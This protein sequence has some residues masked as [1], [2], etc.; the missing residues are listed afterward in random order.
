MV[1][2]HT[3]KLF[4]KWKGGFAWTGSGAP[5]LQ[6]QMRKVM[7]LHLQARGTPSSL[8][9]QRLFCTYRI[10][11]SSEN[12]F[13]IAV[14]SQIQ[15]FGIHMRQARSKLH[16]NQQDYSQMDT[17]AERPWFKYAYLNRDICVILEIRDISCR[18]LSPLLLLGVV[19][20]RW[21]P[22]DRTRAGCLG[23]LASKTKYVTRGTE[24]GA[25]SSHCWRGT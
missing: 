20:V 16:W 5:V 7:Q 25:I 21:W 22:S 3:L 4:L 13:L 12:V 10:N 18:Q 24:I 14:I 2:V 1:Y 6:K 8:N 9:I 11:T 19:V 23:V 17:I 15:D